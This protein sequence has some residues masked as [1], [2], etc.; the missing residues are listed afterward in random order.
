MGTEGRQFPRHPQTQLC[1][2]Q[3]QSLAG[4]LLLHC[5]T[6]KGRTAF[7]SPDAAQPRAFCPGSLVSAV[8]SIPSLTH[9]GNRL[10]VVRRRFLSLLS[11]RQAWG[12]QAT[13]TNCQAVTQKTLQAPVASPQELEE[14]SSWRTV[15]RAP[16]LSQS[17]LEWSW[18][19]KMGY[20][21]Y[22]EGTHTVVLTLPPT[23]TISLP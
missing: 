6:H 20:K 12:R 22:C 17:S 15:G 13:V 14:S 3:G 4:L 16:T 8:C 18:G 11:E 9:H 2:G 5:S 7:E 23:N 19:S 10:S 21:W 1:K